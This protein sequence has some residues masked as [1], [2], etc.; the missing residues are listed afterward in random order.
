MNKY[1]NKTDQSPA[2][3]TALLLNPSRK[4]QYINRFWKLEQRQ[5]A[6]DKVKKLQEDEYK[7]KTTLS[8]IP[9]TPSTSTNEFELQL[10][11]INTPT[12]ALDEYEQYYKADLVFGY[13]NALDW[14]L[15]P[16][17]RLAYPNLSKMAL[18]MLSIPAM[19]SDPERVFL[20][21][22]ITLTD[23]RNKLGMKMIEFLECLKSWTSKDEQ[24]QGI[25]ATETTKNDILV[26]PGVQE[27][28]GDQVKADL[29]VSWSVSSAKLVSSVSFRALITN[30]RSFQTPKTAVSFIAIKLVSSNCLKLSTTL[31]RPDLPF[32][33]RLWS[34]CLPT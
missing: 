28:V 34:W 20:A 33:R 9:S 5:S 25:Q 19:S 6:K 3:A 16:A 13:K 14:Q 29:Q 31:V 7:P 11:A 32:C 12:Q 15:E 22:K 10:N 4:W 24:E 17:Q 26:G 23:R 27:V 2:Y 30:C 1:Y 8:T 18:D 21:A